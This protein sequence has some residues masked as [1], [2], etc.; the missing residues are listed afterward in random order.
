VRDNV[1]M[2]DLNDFASVGLVNHG[3]EAKFCSDM[4][5]P[6]RRKSAFDRNAGRQPIRRNQQKVVLARWLAL[7]QK[8]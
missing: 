5:G 3:A 4:G 6:A 2:P 8:C 7:S 1:T